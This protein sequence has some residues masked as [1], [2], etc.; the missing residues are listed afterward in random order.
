MQKS[1]GPLGFYLL[2]PEHRSP[3]GP[4]IRS[5][6]FYADLIPG[7]MIGALQIRTEQPTPVPTLV[8][9]PCGQQLRRESRHWAET[10][11]P[12]GTPKPHSASREGTPPQ[13]QFQ[14]ANQKNINDHNTKRTQCLML[15]PG[16]PLCP[17]AVTGWPQGGTSVQSHTHL[18]PQLRP[19][20]T[21]VPSASG[22]AYF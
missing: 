22:F 18:P 13:G 17:S 14:Q 1:K 20:R 16:W 5:R 12:T 2:P 3:L 6:V 10:W 15:A 21:T 4:G 19:G 11:G 8:A 7:Y 9:H